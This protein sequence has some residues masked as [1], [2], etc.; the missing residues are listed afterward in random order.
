MNSMV[1]PS[2]SRAYIDRSRCRPHGRRFHPLAKTDSDCGDGAASAR[3]ESE[4]TA[5]PNEQWWNDRRSDRVLPSSLPD[6][7]SLV[8]TGDTT[9]HTARSVHRGNVFLGTPVAG[10]LGLRLPYQPC[11]AIC[12]T[13]LCIDLD[14]I[15]AGLPLT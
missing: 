6:R 9:A 11:S 3:S 4:H 5:K 2:E 8:R 10:S 14:T 15:M 12:D 1:L 13:T 7:G